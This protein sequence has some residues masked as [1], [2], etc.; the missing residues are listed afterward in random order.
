MC[1]AY[2]LTEE[3]ARAKG[4]FKDL[5]AALSTEMETGSDEPAQA[6]PAQVSPDENSALSPVLGAEGFTNHVNRR[7]KVSGLLGRYM[8]QGCVLLDKVCS[9]CDTGT[10]LLRKQGKGAD[11]R[12][13]EPF[14]VNCSSFSTDK[15]SNLGLPIP[16]KK[17]KVD[18]A[19]REEVAMTEV[20][21]EN[22]Q[23]TEVAEEDSVSGSLADHLLMGWAMLGD[24]CPAPNCSTPL[25]KDK[26]GVIRCLRC[27]ISFT[28]D[29][30]QIEQQ[31]VEAGDSTIAKPPS[32]ERKVLTSHEA[33]VAVSQAAAEI[34]F[35]QALVR[36]DAIDTLYMGLDHSQRSLRKA[37][38]VAQGDQEAIK[39]EL[40]RIEVITRCI[41]GLQQLDCCKN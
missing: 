25:M 31:S 28:A 27:Q 10:P 29:G 33:P 34:Q 13:Q 22:H 40:D 4:S 38:E 8:M 23:E 37:L 1:R 39:A 19:A 6:T 36:A 9:D 11:G 17:L 21:V 18:P 2:C 12:E 3:E 15:Q 24:C 32:S 5:H 26:R 20:E 16:P 14:C 30:K 41:T 35:G 7:D